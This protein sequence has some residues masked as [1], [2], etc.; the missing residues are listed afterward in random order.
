MNSLR[1]IVR[2]LTEYESENHDTIRDFAAQQFFTLGHNSLPVVLKMLTHKDADVREDATLLL[3]RYTSKHTDDIFVLLDQ[4]EIVSAVAGL[5]TAL[6][7]HAEDVVRGACTALATYR[8]AALPALSKI[9]QLMMHNNIGIVRD[10]VYAV[11]QLG[12]HGRTASPELRLVVRR[13]AVNTATEQLC[14]RAII[15]MKEVGADGPQ[16]L[17]L[18]AEM[19]A[20]SSKEI[21][22][23]A[24]AALKAHGKPVP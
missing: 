1:E 2:G 19:A 23:V 8:K 4:D 22:D 13:F 10:A 16:D 7:D 6:D 12:I 15:A 5:V 11:T 21:A 3:E 20:S 24:K 18:Y 14:S 17:T 9:K